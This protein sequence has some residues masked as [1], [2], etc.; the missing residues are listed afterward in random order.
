[1]DTNLFNRKKRNFKALA[2]RVNQLIL[3]GE[4]IRLSA[5]T[6]NRIILKLNSLYRQL[7]SYFTQ[8][9]LKKI[10]AAA[11]IFI[12]FP[13]AMQAQSFAP[14][15]LNPFWLVPDSVSLASPKFADIDNDEDFDLFTGN[16]GGFMQYYENT[17]TPAVPAFALPQQNPFGIVTPVDNYHIA[18]PAF[19]DIDHDGDLDLFIGG[20]AGDEP[21]Y[22]DL[23][24][25]YENTGTDVAPAFAAPQTNPFGLE[26]GYMFAMPAFA[27]IDSDGDLDLF[28]GEGYGAFKFFENTGTVA[29][30][31]FAV[32]VQNPFG[33]T[34]VNSF[35]SPAFADTDHDGDLDLFVGEYYG[36]M[37]YFENTGTETSPAFAARVTNPFGLV[38]T[39]YYNFPAI[40]DLDNDGDEDIMIGEYYGSLQYFKNTEFNTGIGENPGEEFFSLYPNPATDMVT[41][42]LIDKN[43]GKP[44]Q[45][46]ITDLNGRVVKTDIMKTDDLKLKTDDLAP[47]V[48]F[49]RV[50]LEENVFTRK[51]VV[52]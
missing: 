44:M 46:S 39:N 11:A 33:L 27:D 3:S 29:E 50:V 24:Q 8:R 51:L 42:K 5:S 38:Q 17:G 4:W 22:A 40:A 16:Y 34:S 21:G 19:A 7:C 35:G 10:L 28:T 32:P 13:L 52:R 1:M 18:F 41:I 15:L 25:Y 2:G 31:E 36:N 48:Y 49:V 47:G 14:P 37:Q 12:G 45:V 6:R 30:P 43:T 26:P 9:E 20:I 23:L